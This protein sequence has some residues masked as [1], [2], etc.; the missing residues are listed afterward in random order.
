MRNLFLLNIL[1]VGLYLPTYSQFD[2]RPQNYR[3]QID[4]TFMGL[5]LTNKLKTP[6][7]FENK[8]MGWLFNDLIHY[9]NYLYPQLSDKKLNID[10]DLFTINELTQTIDNMPCVKP[11]GFSPMPI[12]EPDSTVRY[13]LLIRRL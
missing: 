10:H 1:I 12:F 7:L 8:N 6:S 11:Q 3:L 4:T 9:R 5:S 13:T 2:S